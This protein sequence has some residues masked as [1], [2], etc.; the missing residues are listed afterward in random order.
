MPPRGDS[1]TN[2]HSISQRQPS[3]GSAVPKPNHN[4]PQHRPSMSSVTPAPL[5]RQISDQRLNTASAHTP[6]VNTNSRHTP[7]ALASIA[8]AARYAP[9]MPQYSTNYKAPQPVEV[10]H[11]NDAANASIPPDIREQ[12]ERD[13]YGR[14]L[15]FTAP[16]LDTAGGVT[17]VAHLGHSARY[18]AAKLK[19]EEARAQQ[20]TPSPNP[21]GLQKQ[22]DSDERNLTGTKPELSKTMHSWEEQSAAG[23]RAAF[24]EL[25]GDD[26]ERRMVEELDRIAEA[27]RVNV[28]HEEMVAE[29]ARQRYLKRKAQGF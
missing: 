1:Q 14:V 26:W 23:T 12:F 6:Q 8:P 20:P 11:L 22:Q 5:T 21:N 28:R 18:L 9:A 29:H 25:Y 10:W 16:P 27:Q 19:R 3:V 24:R 4:I 15:F 7:L 2:M 13:E 17:S